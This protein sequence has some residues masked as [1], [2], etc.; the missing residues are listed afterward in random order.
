LYENCVAV[1]VQR[2]RP[3]VLVM[4]RG[5][6]LDPELATAAGEVGR[7]SRGEGQVQRL[8][9]HPREHQHLARAVPLDDRRDQ[10]GLVP[11]DFRGCDRASHGSRF[12]LIEDL[13]PKSPRH[14]RFEGYGMSS[15]WGYLCCAPFSGASSLPSWPDL[16]PRRPVARSRG[17]WSGLTRFLPSRDRPHGRST[18]GGGTCTNQRV[19][20]ARKQPRLACSWRPTQRRRTPARRRTTPKTRRSTSPSPH[21]PLPQKRKRPPRPKPPSRKRTPPLKSRRRP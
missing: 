7:P 6:A 21:K 12:F 2:H 18:D 15:P 14:A 20:P 17:H 11:G 10:T 8:G 19:C 16:R 4:P 9:V 3:H 13:G 5:L 1:T